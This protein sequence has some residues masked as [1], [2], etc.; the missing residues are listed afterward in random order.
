MVAVGLL[1]FD[2][3]KGQEWES[4]VRAAA[5][6]YREKFGRAPT[7]CYVH[8]Q[9]LGGNKERKLGRLRVVAKPTVLPHH[10]FVVEE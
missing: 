10:I 2:A 6:R 3:R 4:A 7:V 9:M 1:W 8:P 5:Q